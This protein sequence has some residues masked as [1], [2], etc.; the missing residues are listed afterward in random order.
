MHKLT[1]NKE[2]NV[3]NTT[4]LHMNVSNSI[5]IG[6]NSVKNLAPLLLYITTK[7]R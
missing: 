2:W 6:I 1:K 4:M 3:Y 7:L 5:F